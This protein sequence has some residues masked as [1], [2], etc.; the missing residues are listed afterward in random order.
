MAATKKKGTNG[1]TSEDKTTTAT[2]T[3]LRGEA[4]ATQANGTS[5]NGVSID[6]LAD[7][8]LEVNLLDI[9]VSAED[10][11]AMRRIDARIEEA[12]RAQQQALEAEPSERQ[13]IT[14]AKGKETMLTEAERQEQYNKLREEEL[15]CKALQEK[16]RAQRLQ[17]EKMQ[18]PPPPPPK[19]MA[20]TNPWQH[21]PPRVRSRIIPIEEISDRSESDGEEYCLRGYQRRSPLSEELEEI[22]WPHR[23]NPAVL[24]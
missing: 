2:A 12:R 10:I 7:G 5:S 16:L 24:P 6:A 19:E 18:A 9:G 21:E 17:L 14:R 11:A 3:P 4:A 15:R 1:A 8:Q 20:V 22:Q 13:M 23:L